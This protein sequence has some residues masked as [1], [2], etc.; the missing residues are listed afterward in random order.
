[1]LNSDNPDR[2]SLYGSLNIRYA[3]NRHFC[4]SW[5]QAKR[6]RKKTI[7]SQNNDLLRPHHKNRGNSRASFSCHTIFIDISQNV[8]LPWWLSG[9]EP[10][11]Q[12]RRRGFYFWVRKIPWRR[13][14]QPTPVFLSG[15]SYGQ[16]S[17]EGSSPW[18]HKRV[19]HDL[20]TK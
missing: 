19:G 5:A 6:P 16:R 10:T 3:R 9:N 20:A 14:W 4:W 17:L 13:K 15:K 1:M 18:L 12:C 7:R 2:S 8:G 11:C